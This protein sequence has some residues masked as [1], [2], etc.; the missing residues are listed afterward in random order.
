V[1]IDATIARTSHKS[2]AVPTL[3]PAFA[4]PNTEALRQ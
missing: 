2:D 3:D 4:D 1:T